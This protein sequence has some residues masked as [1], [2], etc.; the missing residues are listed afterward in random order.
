[1]ATAPGLSLPKQCG[2][3]SDLKAAYRL[4]SHPRI[5]PQALQQP[6]RRHTRQQCV[7]HPVVLCIQDDTTL[8]FNTRTKVRGLGPVG[9]K[10]AGQGLMQHTTLAALPDGRL[11][12][13]LDQ[14]WFHRVQ[15]H[16]ETRRERH[17]R[18]RETQVWSDAVRTVGTAPAGTRWVHVMDRAADDLATMLECQRQGAGFVIR[19]RHDRR[20]EGA[21]DKL[22][23][24]MGAMPAAE[25][26]DV[27]VTTQR[28]PRG[29][30]RRVA[31]TARVQVRYGRVR[32]EPP[33]NHPGPT[34]PL[35][36]WAVYAREV[37]APADAEPIDWLLLTSEPLDDLA[38]ARRV[39][40]WY[41]GRWLIE[42]WHRVEKEGCK[43]EASQLD[44]AA[45]IQRLAA[46]VG[47]IAVRLL[48][49][50]D[51]AEASVTDASS[52]DD[53]ARLQGT[54]PSMWI[55]MAAALAQLEPA[56]LTPRQFWRTI[57]KRGGWIGRRRDGRPGWKAIWRG[58]YD[59]HCMVQGAQLLT[60]KPVHPKSG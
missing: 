34:E 47:V 49:L 11:L 28:D 58:W 32:L 33:W 30:V 1:M 6:H 60:Q 22:W 18:W 10:E 44:D 41:E 45:D 13:V 27:D 39:M 16:G 9:G 29:R 3:W 43:L 26:I 24:W 42:E 4:L 21:T 19:A 8:S 56:R 17:Q 15:A 7:G 40:G 59:L 14:F 50:R 12:G 31:R 46:I 23:S 5:D 37:D 57:A 54:V 55:V 52:A 48:Q 35:T 51:L 53:P 2:D 38:A 36:V 20:V 25:T